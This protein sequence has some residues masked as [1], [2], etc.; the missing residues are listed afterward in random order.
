MLIFIIITLGTN[1]FILRNCVSNFSPFLSDMSPR[2]SPP[3]PTEKTLWERFL[4]R[5]VGLHNFEWHFDR[6]LKLGLP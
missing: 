6:L 5:W 4:G 3:P 1:H 2:A